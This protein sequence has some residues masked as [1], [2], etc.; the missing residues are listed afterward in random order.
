MASLVKL[1]LVAFVLSLYSEYKISDSLNN[2][3]SMQ[4]DSLR[5]I[6]TELDSTLTEC[7]IDNDSLYKEMLYYQYRGQTRKIRSYERR[8]GKGK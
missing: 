7:A 4:I 2:R 3:Y 8:I 1:F 5:I 6:N